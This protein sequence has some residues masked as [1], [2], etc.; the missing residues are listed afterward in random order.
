MCIITEFHIEMQH[1]TCTKSNEQSLT[2]IEHSDE[3]VSS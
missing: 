3:T 1:Y 2:L